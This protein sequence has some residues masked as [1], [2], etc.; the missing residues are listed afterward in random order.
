MLVAVATRGGGSINEHFGHAK[1]FQIY[2]VSPAGIRFVGHRRVEQYCQGGWGEDATLDGVLA[3]LQGVAC[4]LVAK[5]G[6]CP[7][8]SLASAGIEA[9]QGHAYDWIESGIAA[10]YGTRYS[11]PVRLTA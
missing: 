5:I 9:T 6:D 1:E 3:T 7:R 8:E 4:V 2:E 10:W 11:Q